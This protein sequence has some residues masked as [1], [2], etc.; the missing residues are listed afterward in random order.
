MKRWIV[1]GVV[2]V[3]TAFAFAQ[4]AVC[5]AIVEQAL[6]S[7]GDA[8]QAL[9]RNQ[10][11]YGYNQV[12]AY[13]ADAQPVPDFEAV[14]DI[15]GLERLSR[16]V[17]FALDTA[18]S[19][20]GVALLALQAN[21]PDTLP[22]QNVTIV[23]FGLIE[24]ES[25]DATMQAFRFVSGIGQS[26]CAEIPRDGLLVQT[27]S[28][29]GTVSF[30]INGIQVDIGSTVVLRAAA[31]SQ[32]E[33]STL[34]GTA[35]VTSAGASETVQAGFS[36]TVEQGQPPPEPQPLPDGSTTA[37][38]LELL[39]EAITLPTIDTATSQAEDTAAT[40]E[41]TQAPSTVAVS[42]ERVVGIVI[43]ANRGGATVPSGQGFVLRIGWRDPSL[44]ALHEYIASAQQTMTYDGEPLPLAATEGPRSVIVEGE[45]RVTFRFDW[46]FAVPAALPGAHEAI[47]DDGIGNSLTCTLTGE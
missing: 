15:V 44:S 23:A 21:L 47:W 25:E 45:E 14:G 9:G 3:I 32:I 8:C 24:L 30:N 4:D 2:F 16:L 10:V 20:W 40:P 27:P 46:F 38:P 29:V 28:G 34:E 19:D 43:C 37:L 7:V 6:A 42:F 33:V 11:C 5:P 39:P 31:Q 35:T 36:V 1:I 17:T 18:T 26:Q 22:G 13:D 12:A 41:T